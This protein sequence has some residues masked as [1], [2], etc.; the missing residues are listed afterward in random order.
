[1][2]GTDY[3]FK[4]FDDRFCGLVARVLAADPEVWVRFPALPDFS[5]N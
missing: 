3:L 5:E 4:T 1:M 2:S